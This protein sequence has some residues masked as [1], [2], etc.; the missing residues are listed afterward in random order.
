L[1]ITQEMI[2]EAKSYL[3]IIDYVKK[4]PSVQ[5]KKAGVGK[6][7]VNPCPLC[8]HYDH[9]FVY[10]YTNTYYSFSTRQCS[11]GGSIIDFI[12]N[13][14]KVPRAEAV[15]EV[16]ELYY[17][18]KFVVISDNELKR[19]I[20]KEV[21]RNEYDFEDIIKKA[22]KYLVENGYSK[23]FKNRG[24]GRNLIKKYRLGYLNESIFNIL[25]EKTSKKLPR[26][27]SIL[28]PVS[29]K[30][31]ILRHDPSQGGRFENKYI[32]LGKIE[33]FNQH[34][35]FDEAKDIVF[36]AEGIFDALSLESAYQKI[37]VTNDRVI[38]LSIN[39]V[40]NVKKFAELIVKI[41]P[42]RIIIAFDND[43]AGEQAREEV[44]KKIDKKHKIDILKSGKYKD[45]NEMYL[46]EPGL[47]VAKMRKVL[48]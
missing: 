45:I 4:I 20:K 27:F 26:Q 19:E 29:R 39:S 33:F 34:E 1:K 37:T 47:L 42:K 24:I 48:D 23:Y 5:F 2:F 43:P 31:I 40:A 15:R 18:N 28:L 17:G 38:F 7:L 35:L 44:I 25:E 14:K 6:V 11:G 9:F 16:I 30:S 13:F 3:S 10:E 12:M 21:N 32:V 8:G 36:V 22:H 41:P 46:E